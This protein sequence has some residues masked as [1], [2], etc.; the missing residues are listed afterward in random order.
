[1]KEINTVLEQNAEF[2]KVTASTGCV[3]R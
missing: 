3:Y 2:V 1:M